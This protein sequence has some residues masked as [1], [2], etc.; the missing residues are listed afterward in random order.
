[1]QINIALEWFLNPDHLPFI[2]GVMRGT[3]KEAG[4]EVEIIEPK[5]HYDGFEALKR[6]S[7]DIHVNEPLH[8]Y[9]HHFDG[10]KSLGCF[11]ET[12]GGVMIRKERVAKLKS[13]GTIKIT[14]PAANPVTDKI[15]FEIIK[16][17]ANKNGFV[18]ERENV[19]FVETDF[20]HLANM[21]K[22]PSF[23]GAWLCFY[24]FEGV[25][26]K[27]L[28]FENLF[29]DQFESPYPN[30][31]ALEL[32]TTQAIM[33]QKG[34]ALC[35]FIEVTNEMIAYIQSYPMEAKRLYYDYTKTEPSELMDKIIEDTLTRFDNDIKADSKRW[36]ALYEFLEELEL[37]KLD[38]ASYEKIWATP[39]H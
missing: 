6:G 13:N 8:L 37:V 11:F 5:E 28:G 21:Q 34:E 22:D 33:E 23:D 39:H 14:T 32:M 27:L 18:I 15:G 1:M 35:K 20:W 36:R 7:I 30:F 29:I 3:Y 38:D 19:E 17:Y 31:S 25:E 26:A 16:R 9:E 24:N 10:L 4:L 2:A 12:R